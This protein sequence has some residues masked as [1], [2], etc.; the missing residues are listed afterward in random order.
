M[1]IEMEYSIIFTKC[2]MK[3]III[4]IVFCLTFLVGCKNSEESSITEQSGDI[5]LANIQKLSPQEFEQ[6]S[7]EKKQNFIAYIRRPDCSDCNAFEPDLLKYMDENKDF[8]NKVY[9]V[10]ITSIFDDKNEWENFKLENKINGTPSF[11]YIKDGKISS[12]S[13]WTVEKGYS[14]TILDNWVR[15]LEN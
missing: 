2:I 12:S 14:V 3:K 1:K 11:V 6:K 15:S 7:S 13:S 10:D 9:F 8:K 5:D 4:V